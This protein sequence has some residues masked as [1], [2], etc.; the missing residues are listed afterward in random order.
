MCVCLHSSQTKAPFILFYCQ[1]TRR[2]LLQRIQRPFQLLQGMAYQYVAPSSASPGQ[3]AATTVRPAF[4]LDDLL[5]LRPPA[6]RTPAGAP[7]PPPSYPPPPVND[8]P[9]G[10]NANMRAAPLQPQQHPTAFQ[11]PQPQQQPTA[12]Q[13]TQPL[14]SVAYTPQPLPQQQQLHYN[15]SPPVPAAPAPYTYASGGSQMPIPQQPPAVISG[16][17]SASALQAP[18]GYYGPPPPGTHSQQAV[19]GS[20]AYSYPVQ[21]QTA[22]VVPTS[23]PLQSGAGSVSAP[24]QPA[25]YPPQQQQTV[26]FRPS[27]GGAYVTPDPPQ[28]AAPLGVSAALPAGAASVVSVASSDDDADRL[29]LE[30]I[31]RLRKELEREQEREKQK[32]EER[33]TWACAECTFRNKL[34]AASCEMCTAVRPGSVV[35]PLPQASTAA[36]PSATSA[37]AASTAALSAG[38]IPVGSRWQCSVCGTANVYQN[39]NCS[40][41]S[42]YR[43][44]GTPL[45]AA[46]AA[47]T[48]AG[49][50]QTP[51][52]TGTVRPPAAAAASQ[53][54]QQW[55]CNVCTLVN[56]ISA[57]VCSACESGQRP[58]HMLPQPQQSSTPVAT[59]PPPSMVPLMSA[60]AAQQ[61]WACSRCTFENQHS[62]A[63]CNMCGQTRPGGPP[64]SHSLPPYARQVGAAQTPQVQPSYPYAAAVAGAQRQSP[65]QPTPVVPQDDDDAV[66]WQQDNAVANCNKCNVQFGMLKRRH[67]CRACGFVFCYD[68]CN[69]KVALKPGAQPVKVC[70]DCAKEKT[71]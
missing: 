33:E 71:R 44:N 43:S 45:P 49:Q 11:Q 21:P 66:Q 17:Q 57:A 19:Y 56:P 59:A 36:R 62:A 63:S 54:V 46:N 30:K 67:H 58:R 20:S 18:Y 14:Q 22:P 51:A 13:P 9:Y 53:Q 42:A 48:T 35:A 60:V 41:C 31:I 68:C 23:Q 37:P 4:D 6:D 26:E 65:S 39:A 25:A 12:F 7:M 61:P 69:K 64:M 50:Q 40:A 8:D 32:R 28:S 70:T 47:E 27:W 3:A 34:T 5:D 52:Y 2:S 38:G 24:V 16:S 55:E 15:V 29:Q 10:F 1:I